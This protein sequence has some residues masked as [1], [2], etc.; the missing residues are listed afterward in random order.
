MRVGK[1][2]GVRRTGMGGRRK[3]GVRREGKGGR[4]GGGSRREGRL[5]TFSDLGIWVPV[6]QVC[7]GCEHSV[8][9]DCQ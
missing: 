9:F 8:A 1:F 2:L 4:E 6:R 3:G 7:L 5:P